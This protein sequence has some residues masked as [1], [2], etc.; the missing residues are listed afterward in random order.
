MSRGEVRY[1]K[2]I[3]EKCSWVRGHGQWSEWNIFSDVFSGYVHTFIVIFSKWIF[4]PS[5]YSAQTRV[6][7]KTSL[8]TQLTNAQTS[9]PDH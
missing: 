6:F 4:T 3:K 8:S 9:A 1:E 7:I 2:G 5:V